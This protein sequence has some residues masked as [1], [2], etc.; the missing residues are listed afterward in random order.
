MLRRC[1]YLSS[2]EA[3]NSVSLL[4]PYKSCSSL[5]HW[6]DVPIFILVFS[7]AQ[8]NSLFYSAFLRQSSYFFSLTWAMVGHFSALLLLSVLLHCL[9]FGLEH[10]WPGKSRHC[11]CAGEGHSP[12]HAMWGRGAASMHENDWHFS[13]TPLGSDWS[14]L[15][16]SGGFLQIK[17][18]SLDGATDSGFLHC[19]HLSYSTVRL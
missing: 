11:T 19:W 15:S 14:C 4:N 3:A 6:N 5:H 7:L 12:L 10:I 18:G 13:D 1:P 8:S 17:L 16:G 2:R 9:Q